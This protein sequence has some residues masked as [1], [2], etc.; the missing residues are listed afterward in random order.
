[1]VRVRRGSGPSISSSWK[2]E[3]SPA[4]AS[5]PQPIPIATS[6]SLNSAAATLWWPTRSIT[7][8]AWR[9]SARVAAESPANTTS[10]PRIRS[11]S[12]L[13]GL[14]KSSRPALFRYASASSASAS[15]ARST[16]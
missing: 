16:A 10:R 13:A 5:R 11:A 9:A 15:A 3:A 6:A 14:V 1:M 7:V 12:P 8:A 4:P 2:I